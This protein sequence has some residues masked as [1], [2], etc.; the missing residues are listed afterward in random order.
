M[1]GSLPLLLLL[2]GDSVFPGGLE[3]AGAGLAA[4]NTGLDQGVGRRQ[5]GLLAHEVRP[6][7]GLLRAPVGEHGPARRIDVLYSHVQF[8]S[9]PS[10]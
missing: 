4:G 2:L 7:V 5:L 1:P 8:H 9:L 6:G 3:G 10:G